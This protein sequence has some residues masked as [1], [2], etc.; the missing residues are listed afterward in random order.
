MSNELIARSEK[1]LALRNE[2]YNLSIE[3]G[4]LVVREVPYV[5]SASKPHSDGMLVCEF[6]GDG[7]ATNIYHTM[8]FAGEY[9]CDSHGNPLAGLRNSSA[10]QVL[11]ADPDLV[12][13]HNFSAKPD[14]EA[15]PNYYE[16][17]T[18]YVEIISGPAKALDKN[19]TAKTFPTILETRTD[20][21][22]KYIDTS[23]ARAKI[24]AV[25]QKL[26]TEKVAIIGLGG[27]GSY[28]LDLV[29]KTP[30]REIHLYDKDVFSQHNAFRSPGAASAEVFSTK[31]KKV[32]YLNSIY[33]NLR[34]LL[35]PHEENV[36]SENAGELQ[37]M[38]MVFICVDKN[39]ARREIIENLERLGISFIDCG[40]G[41]E[42]ING[43]LSATVRATTSTPAARSHVRDKGR[44]DMS[45][46]CAVDDE[47]ATNIQIADL[48]M[49]N[50]ALAVIKWKKLV[51]FYVDYEHEFHTT[52]TVE[53]NL[54]TSEDKA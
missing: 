29:S 21:P 46:D 18:T 19:L 12:V 36:T 1:L 47:Y 42:V 31:A 30:V 33:S 49:L 32:S 28:V 5:D 53:E 14:T 2:G 40:M 17:V 3:H 8:M 13:D 7:D 6:S 41:V 51:G 16:K 34:N 10:R 26:E 37:G 50:A 44:I 23:S 45:D 48:N 35:I 39:S 27:S 4:Y 54:L 9:P 22:F 38:S 11:H 25:T 20:A 15:Y 24:T 43:A 52:Y